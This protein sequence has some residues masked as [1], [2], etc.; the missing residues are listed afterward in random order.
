VCLI[1]TSLALRCANVGYGCV[2][3]TLGI[4][5]HP[6][7]FSGQADI[8]LLRF[9]AVQVGEQSHLSVLGGP[10]ARWESNQRHCSTS[11]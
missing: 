3:W 6:C 1:S 8:R 4:R 7:H 2:T 5:G 10:L 11:C 9:D